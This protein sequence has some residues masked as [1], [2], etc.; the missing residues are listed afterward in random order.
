MAMTR[1]APSRPGTSPPNWRNERA[2]PC[3]SWTSGTRLPPLCAPF[4]RWGGPRGAGR[5]TSMPSPPPYC[6]NMR[7][8]FHVRRRASIS[9]AVAALAVAAGCGGSSGGASVRVSIPAG[10][11]FGNAVDSLSRAGVISAPRLFRLYASARG[12]D[13]ELKAGTYV[14]QRDASWNDVLDA[15]T[16]GKGLVHTITIP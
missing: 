11:N 13:R 3:V 4:A 14:F 9:L 8:R 7:S 1:R 16:R 10:A 6:Y 2:S 5:E 15:L 12:R